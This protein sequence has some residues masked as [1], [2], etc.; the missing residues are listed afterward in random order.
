MKK[1]VIALLLVMP[2][3]LQVQATPV[4]YSFTY[5][6]DNVYYWDGQVGTY[7]FSYT[8]QQFQ[9]TVTWDTDAA[10]YVSSSA[11]S[12][13]DASQRGC[14]NYQ[15]GVCTVDRGEHPSMMTYAVNTP[16]GVFEPYAVWNGES[17][18]S[19]Y[20]EAQL[21]GTYSSIAAAQDGYSA[22]GTFGADYDFLNTRVFHGMNLDLYTDDPGNFIDPTDLSQILSVQDATLQAT[23][24]MTDATEIQH[25]TT[26]NQCGSFLP[27]SIAKSVTGTLISGA[28]ETTP[29]PNPA[30]A[31]LLLSGIGGLAAVARRR[32]SSAQ[33]IPA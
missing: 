29:V 32:K 4:T 1:F 19:R 13:Y 15:N 30:A 16:F 3:S 21:P 27:G 28:V 7:D 6:V 23:I 33:A 9:G 26:A 12:A 10:T 2:V 31:W 25:C 5:E 22:V 11:N 18:D 8:G 20:N 24:G 14:H 17:A